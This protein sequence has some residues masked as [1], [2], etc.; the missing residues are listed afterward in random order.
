MCCR[1]RESGE[2]ALVECEGVAI[3]GIENAGCR[4]PLE[5]A[6]PVRRVVRHERAVRV[7]V[8]TVAV[9]VGEAEGVT[10]L[11]DQRR[12]EAIRLIREE[13]GV[14]H[15]EI[16]AAAPRRSVDRAATAADRFAGRDIDRDE[17]HV[18]GVAIQ[19]APGQ[20]LAQHAMRAVFRGVR[21]HIDEVR[22][23][24]WRAVDRDRFV[25]DRE[26]GAEQGLVVRSCEVE[27]RAQAPCR[28][29][30]IEHRAVARNE[31]HRQHGDRASADPRSE[32]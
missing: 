15:L 21:D 27:V 6:R 1:W 23:R 22:V 32:I 20:E 18:R 11:V 26:R 25:G 4:A 13:R 9:D 8:M 29:V 28:F 16:T 12:L 5:P 24:V 10:E 7:Q 3:F 2:H 19:A 31:E 14:I 17:H 30:E